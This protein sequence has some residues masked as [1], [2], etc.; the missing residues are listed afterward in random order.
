MAYLT[1][2]EWAREYPLMPWDKVKAM[3]ES[4]MIDPW[5]V[6][7]EFGVKEWYESADIL[8]WMGY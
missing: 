1:A 2:Y 3:V 8:A 4:H 5:D 6:I 7:K